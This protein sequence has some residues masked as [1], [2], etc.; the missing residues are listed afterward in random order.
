M[1]DLS[2]LEFADTD[3]DEMRAEKAHW[4]LVMDMP[5]DERAYFL[6]EERVTEEQQTLA[7]MVHSNKECDE[8]VAWYRQAAAKRLWAYSQYGGDDN[9]EAAELYTAAA[10]NIRRDKYTIAAIRKQR[11]R[12][13]QE[14]KKLRAMTKPTSND[15]QS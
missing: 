5:E 4:Q 2:F 6:Q 8:M 1:I 11:E 15:E 9:L 14:R 7:Q 12:I 3:T 10:K 13:W